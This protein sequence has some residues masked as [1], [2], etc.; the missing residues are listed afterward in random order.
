MRVYGT[1]P[2]SVKSPPLTTLVVLAGGRGRR[3][4]GVPKGLIRLGNGETIVERLLRLARGPAILSANHPEWYE[5]LD[6]PVV[7]DLVPDK[8]APGGVVTGLAMAGTEWVFV[9]A[10]DMPFVSRELLESLERRVHAGVDALCFTRE[11]QLEPLCGLYRRA[12]VHDWAP[13]L[14]GNPSLRALITS[15]RYE[16]LEASEPER[17]ISLNSPEDL[18][19]AAESFRSSG[20]AGTVPALPW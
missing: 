15:S 11:G 20:V 2:S 19:K 12:L 16:T 5:R 4:G 3:L 1:P 8:G 17:L 7:G 13:R 6:V 14:D 18:E 9:V 10:C